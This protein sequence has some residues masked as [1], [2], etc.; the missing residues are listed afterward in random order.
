MDKFFSNGNIYNLFE[1]DEEDD[2]KKI[3]RKLHVLVTNTPIYYYCCIV[4]I[5][6][7]IVTIEKKK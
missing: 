6:I 4:I 3:K 1:V 5:I 7:V 2:L